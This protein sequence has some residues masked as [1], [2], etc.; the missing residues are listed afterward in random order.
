M[1]SL[2]AKYDY[3]EKLTRKVCVSHNR[4]PKKR[5]YVP[6]RGSGV[7]GAPSTKKKKNNQKP[8]KGDHMSANKN[9]PVLKSTRP[10]APPTQ[11]KTVQNGISE[12]RKKPEGGTSQEFDAVD[13]LRQRLHQKI[14]ESR[15]QG[16]PKDPSSEEI[17]K[18]RERRKQERERRKRK[19]KEFRIKKL[20]DAAAL[21]AGEEDKETANDQPQ[22]TSTSS[23]PAKE[24]KSFI[25]FN[26]MEVREDYVDKGTKL[27]EKKKKKK[28]KGTLTPLTGK[29]YKQL[30]TR[31]E[32]RKT[33]L[34]Q[35]REKDEGKAKKEEEK[36]RWSNV[37]YK[38]EGMKIKDNE[39]LLCASLK[40]KEKRKA[41][42]KKKWVQRSQQVVEKMQKRQDKRRRNIKKRKDAKMEKRKQRARKKGCVLP[43]D[44]KKA[45][46]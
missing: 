13:I 6:F 44:L 25:V 4:E 43:E 39:E 45:S 10:A 2:A 22:G 20:A 40:K 41:Q 29:N 11:R 7:N 17:K 31:I 46:L 3:L 34:E 33:H 35:L 18:K 36:M 27:M 12:T 28:V 26:K 9:N 8:T 21:Q 23:A 1:A 30:L 5:P 16:P 38:A 24:E 42:K 32:A 15:G 37:L 14:E 19:R